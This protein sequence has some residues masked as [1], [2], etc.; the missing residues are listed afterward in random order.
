MS[1]SQQAIEMGGR[2]V[3]VVLISF[4]LGIDGV[5]PIYHKTITVCD[6]PHLSTCVRLTTI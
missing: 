2:V 6:S 4:R 1:L 5:E 3:V